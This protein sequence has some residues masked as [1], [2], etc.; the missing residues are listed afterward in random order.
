VT[1]ARDHRCICRCRGVWHKQSDRSGTSSSRVQANETTL[2]VHDDGARSSES[3]PNTLYSAFSDRAQRAA[4]IIQLRATWAVGAASRSPIISAATCAAEG[5]R[6]R[7]YRQ[8]DPARWPHKY[9][10][11][12][13]I[14][15]ARSA[16]EGACVGQA[17]DLA[18]ERMTVP[19]DTAEGGQVAKLTHLLRLNPPDGRSS[20]IE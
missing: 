17:Y 4:P 12:A 3:N 18:D 13:C 7:R 9:T 16:A 2:T 1:R 5:C 6:A 15:N 14:R 19:V 10:G 8:N 11:Q 20:H